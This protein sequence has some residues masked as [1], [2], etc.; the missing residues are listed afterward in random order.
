MILWYIVFHCLERFCCS[1][2]HILKDFKITFYP[3][4]NWL[5]A[6]NQEWKKSG[7][8]LL[9]FLL[10]TCGQQYFMALSF[11]SF[12]RFLARK[13]NKSKNRNKTTT[14][15]KCYTICFKVMEHSEEDFLNRLPTEATE[16]MERISVHLPKHSWFYMI[17]DLMISSRRMF[18]PITWY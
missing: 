9:I 8:L 15:K 4:N 17:D 11:K 18:R 13:Q 3:L 16:R 6:R 12:W 7:D 5:T 2:P 1:L 10:F 14:K